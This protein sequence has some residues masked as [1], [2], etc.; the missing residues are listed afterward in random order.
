MFIVIVI[1]VVILDPISNNQDTKRTIYFVL[2]S[3]G[4]IA[5]LV[6]EHDMIKKWLKN[7]RE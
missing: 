1:G 4:M 7:R 2:L 6:F 3:A 5:V